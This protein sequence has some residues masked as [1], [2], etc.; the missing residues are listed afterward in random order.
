[1]SEISNVTY[2]HL[3]GSVYQLTIVGSAESG[4]TIFVESEGE[5]IGDTSVDQNG[6]WTLST[7]LN[8]GIY[9]L[10]S[11]EKYSDGSLS[12]PSSIQSLELAAYSYDL[13][14]THQAFQMIKT[15]T[16]STQSS[17]SFLNYE[18]SIG[19]YRDETDTT[20]SIFLDLTHNN[21]LSSKNGVIDPWIGNTKAIVFSTADALTSGDLDKKVDAYKY[22]DGSY[23][24]LSGAFPNTVYSHNKNVSATDLYDVRGIGTDINNSAI[25]NVIDEKSTVV[26]KGYQGSYRASDMGYTETWSDY[27]LANPATNNYNGFYNSDIYTPFVDVSGKY[28]SLSCRVSAYDI[29]AITIDTSTNEIVSRI[30]VGS[31]GYSNQEFVFHLTS[32]SDGLAQSYISVPTWYGNENKVTEYLSQ[33]ELVLTKDGTSTTIDTGLIPTQELSSDGNFIFYTK[34]DQD[35]NGVYLYDITAN[36]KI[37][38]GEIEEGSYETQKDLIKTYLDCGFPRSVAAESFFVGA[39]AENFDT[40]K[41]NFVSIYPQ[42]D[43][44]NIPAIG[45]PAAE[46]PISV[47]IDRDS[48][49]NVPIIIMARDDLPLMTQPHEKY[50][51]DYSVGYRLAKSKSDLNADI[52]STSILTNGKDEINT[53]GGDDLVFAKEGNDVIETGNGNDEVYAGS[54]DDLVIGGNGAGDDFYV[55]G[56]GIDTLRYTSA[57]NPVTI[58][59]RFGLAFGLDIGN[60]EFTEFEIIIAGKGSDLIYAS[61]E[62]SQ[63]EGNSGDDRIYGSISE[64]TLIGGDGNDVLDGGSSNDSMIGG[65]GNDTYYVDSQ[66]DSVTELIKEGTDEIKTTLTTF[67]L[68]NNFEILSFN[69]TST[70]TLTFN[71]NSVSNTISG[72]SG[73]DILDG[74]AGADWML[75]EAGDDTYYVDNTKDLITDTSG[76]DTV[77]SSVNFTLLSGLENLTLI[78]NAANAIGNNVANTLTGNS[79]SN[80]LTGNGGNDRLIGGNAK[81]I[82]VGGA[83]SDTFVFNAGDSGQTTKTFDIIKDFAKGAVGTGDLIDYVTI[84]TVGSSSGSATSSQASIN[85]A[86][87][88]ASFAAKSGA[89]LADAIADIASSFNS[90]TDSQGEFAFF[91]VNNKGNYYAFISDGNAGVTANDVVIQLVGVTTINAIDLADGNLNI[92]S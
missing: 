54:G 15:I 81:D 23:T 57:K 20:K 1:M 35:D 66:N 37:K 22:Q 53:G 14:L 33:S 76:S 55:G 69:G 62:G 12:E 68:A 79:K 7:F 19:I 64:D 18:A 38:L 43:N 41:T 71:G 89:S 21:I 5:T 83:G 78:G 40:F 6:E 80:T 25:F 60:D 51:F 85:Q 16:E 92:L 36:S 61:P 49:Q 48:P 88:I 4:S 56:D 34:L 86:T 28:L 52:D 91:K 46:T 65:S 63:I 82:L 39:L 10:T 32:S 50:V 73:N 24:L 2:E 59:A 30:S 3:Y 17:F 58:D 44:K 72:S 75:G 11:V 84:L 67:T 70:E 47:L 9:A 90:T 27:Y 45:S 31:G 42:L 8:T 74:K 29:Q 87:G 77:Y 26:L 13:T